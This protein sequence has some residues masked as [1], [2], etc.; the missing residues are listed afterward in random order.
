[1]I[2]S[3]FNCEKT[4]GCIYVE[5][6]NKSHVLTFVDG[7]SGILSRKLIEMIPYDSMPRIL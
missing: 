6:H 7:I 2:L 3:V 4:Q 5:A 1:M